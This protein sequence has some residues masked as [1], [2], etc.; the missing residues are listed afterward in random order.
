[1]ERHSIAAREARHGGDAVIRTMRGRNALDMR[2]SCTIP[3]DSTPSM[4][5]TRCQSRNK[6]SPGEAPWACPPPP[7][8]RA[9]A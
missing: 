1:M 3:I 5:K 4:L 9:S 8:S 7:P 2:D 6:N